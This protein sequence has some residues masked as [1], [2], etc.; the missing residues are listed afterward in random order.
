M[1]KNHLYSSLWSS[2]S[3]LLSLVI[4]LFSSIDPLLYVNYQCNVSWHHAII[5]YLSGTG[6]AD[7]CWG[8]ALWQHMLRAVCVCCSRW[9]SVCVSLQWMLIS[10]TTEFNIGV[11]CDPESRAIG[12]PPGR[13][14]REDRNSTIVKGR[15]STG[16]TVF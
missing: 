7:W 12:F 11:S 5:C 14:F 2:S 4:Y 15:G 3:L 13:G 6:A 10:L 1:L 9:P 8:V 16:I